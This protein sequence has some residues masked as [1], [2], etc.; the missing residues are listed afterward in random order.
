MYIWMTSRLAIGRL[1]RRW[2]AV[3]PSKGRA[4]QTEPSVAAR[5]AFRLE[6]CESA[7]V[8]D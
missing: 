7:P 4:L 2:F 6:F 1:S 3:K 5:S 8:L